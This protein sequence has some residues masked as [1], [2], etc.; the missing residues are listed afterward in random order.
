LR[1]ED[2]TWSADG[3]HLA[4]AEQGFVLLRDGDLWLMDAATGEITNIDDDGFS[5]NII[6][7][8]SDEASDQPVSLPV[9][10][11]F[12]PD[13]K[14]IAFS[15]SVVQSG[16]WRGNDIAIVS[17]DGGEVQSLV[18]VTPDTPGV[19]YLGVR[20]AP[21]GSKIYYAVHDPDRD[22]PH[23]GVW[24]VDADGQN[25]RQV[26]PQ[27]DPT[28]GA[29]AVAQVAPDGKTLLIYYPIAVSARTPGEVP[30][31]AIADAETGTLHPILV[32]DP[33][34]PEHSWVGLATLS[35]DGTKVLVVTRFTDT[36]RQVWVSDL[37]GSNAMLLGEPLSESGWVALGLIPTWASDGSVLIPGG[38]AFSTATL[39]RIEGSEAQPVTTTEVPVTPG[40]GTPTVL[41]GEIAPGA[42]VVVNDDGVRMRSAPSRDA[43]AVLE[44]DRG[45]ELEVIG[46][47]VEAEG[48]VWW[49]VEEP[50]TRTIGWVRAEFLS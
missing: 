39:L 35:P 23:N 13:G 9:G 49:P 4:F 1:I 20:W 18:Q 45:T 26:L 43:A 2:V 14:T 12:S 21:D 7:L 46:E 32:P 31:F 30:V 36:D 25:Q 33:N 15:R 42:T 48:F 16:E 3:S 38:G 28:M 41:G 50:E 40:I 37:D 34:A 11:A 29:P 6:R 22:Q 19:V 10:P 17:V 24:V 47:S 27:T 8:S 44:L 5:G